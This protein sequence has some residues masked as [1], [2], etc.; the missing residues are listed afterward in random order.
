MPGGI[1]TLEEL[2]EVMT[3][4]QLGFQQTVGLLNTEGSTII[5]CNL[6]TMLQRRFHRRRTPAHSFASDP[7]QSYYNNAGDAIPD[8]KKICR[9]TQTHTI[10]VEALLIDRLFFWQCAAN[11]E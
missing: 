5:C 8:H 3:W 11:T 1:G 9:I 2:F 10:F 7:A 6:S 4:A